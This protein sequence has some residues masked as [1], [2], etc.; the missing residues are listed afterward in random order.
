M[1]VPGTEAANLLGALSLH[2][3]G[4]LRAAVAGPAGAGGVLADALIVIKDQPGCTVDWLGRALEVSQPGAVHLVHKLVDLDWVHKRAGTDARSKALHLTADGQDVAA[5]ILRARA[6]VLDRL[7]AALSAEQ[8]AQLAAIASALLGPPALDERTLAHLC[9]LCDRARCR[10]CPV[11]AGY[12]SR[13][14][15]TPAPV[16]TRDARVP[17]PGD[18]GTAR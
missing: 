6:A 5:A 12:L 15:A 18:A 3:T 10:H 13:T 11:H 16:S 4:Q 14:A 17:T 9:R 7:V 2:V 1:H 8:R